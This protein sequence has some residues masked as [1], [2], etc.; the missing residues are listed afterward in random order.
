MG[1][2]RI[3]GGHDDG[4]SIIRGQ[5]DGFPILPIFPTQPSV[6]NLLSDTPRQPVITD[7]GG[8][9][10]HRSSG[11]LTLPPIR[12]SDERGRDGR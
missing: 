12:R 11:E 3:R 5:D 2:L 8:D 9:R 4:Y 10:E 1:D 6:S 7:P